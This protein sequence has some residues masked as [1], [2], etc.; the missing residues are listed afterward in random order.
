MKSGTKTYIS[1]S[2]QNNCY[3][4]S[5]TEIISWSNYGRPIPLKIENLRTYI[6]CA[7]YIYIKK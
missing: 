6:C 4:D 7:D 1:Y 2:R 5:E 3:A